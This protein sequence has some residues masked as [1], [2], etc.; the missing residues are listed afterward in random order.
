MDEARE[1]YD[2]NKSVRERPVPYDFTHMWNLRNNTNERREKET[3]ANQ[4]TDC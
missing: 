3:E 1:Y 2:N 4:E